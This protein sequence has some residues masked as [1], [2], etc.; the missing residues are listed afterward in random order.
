MDP[1]IE[2]L[3]NEGLE[4]IRNEKYASAVDTFNRLYDSFTEEHYCSRLAEAYHA[5]ATAADFAAD[6]T[7]KPYTDALKRMQSADRLALQLSEQLGE[8]NS[9]M[10]D[11]YTARNDIYDAYFKDD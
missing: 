10:I 9:W 5:L 7:D 11:F 4:Q 3:F 2:I 1:N 8:D 6:P